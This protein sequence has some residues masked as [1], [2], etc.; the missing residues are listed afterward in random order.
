MGATLKRSTAQLQGIVKRAQDLESE[1]RDLQ[2]QAEDARAAASVNQ[3]DAAKIGRLI[4]AQTEQ[5]FNEQ[6]NQ[7]VSRHTQEVED[8]QKESAKSGKRWGIV[9]LLAG[10]PIGLL[11]N[12]VSSLIQG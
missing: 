5:R 8:L 6:L 11:V 1:V 12:W 7:L 10:V 3:D 4:A 2:Q 9:G